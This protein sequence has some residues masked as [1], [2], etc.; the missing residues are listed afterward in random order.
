[1]LTTLLVLS[2]VCA[3][4]LYWGRR[5]LDTVRPAVAAVD[6]YGLMVD[7]TPIMVP[8][9]AG[10]QRAEWRATADEVRRSATLWQRMHLANWNA[11]PEPLRTEG[12]DNMLV[13]YRSILMNP[14]AWDSMQ[15]LDWDLVPQPMRT[16]AYRQ[17]A[18]Y[19]A[20]YYDVGGKDELPPRVVADTL[21]AIIM[22]ES[23]FDHRGLLVNPDGSRDIGLSGASDFARERLRQLH[24]HGVVDVAF[25]DEGYSNPWVA[26][27]FVALWMSLLLD[28]AHGD[29]DLAIRAYNRGIASAGDDLGTQYLE[30][31]HR[32]L[33]RFI[34]NQNAPPAWAYV[35]QWARE[36][37]R[38]EW[39]WVMGQSVR[40]AS[41]A[42]SLGR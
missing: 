35:W 3:I 15:P 37:E 33:S 24:D 4:A 1:M 27:R 40:A 30:A 16:I 19:W 25:S 26:T 29:L 34:R 9:F 14:R 6:I 28:E 39:P 22:S 10:D 23:W 31:V 11:V 42:H 2:I 18:A 17:M 41:H 21:A 32:R 5:S 20:G 7:S 38:L 36:L 12:L 13:R 8:V